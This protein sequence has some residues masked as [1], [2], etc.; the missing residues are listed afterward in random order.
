MLLSQGVASVTKPST[1]VYCIALAGTA[2]T[3]NSVGLATPDLSAAATNPGESVMVNSGTAFN[4]CNPSTQFEVDFY[5]SANAL[6]D[7]GFIFM[8]P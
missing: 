1:G 7:G 8:V 3:T 6:S 4:D 5:N 2:N